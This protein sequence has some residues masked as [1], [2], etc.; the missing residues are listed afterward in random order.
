[1][2]TLRWPCAGF[3]LL[4]ISLLR[5]HLVTALPGLVVG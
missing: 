4:A 3:C 5:H 2:F 1:M